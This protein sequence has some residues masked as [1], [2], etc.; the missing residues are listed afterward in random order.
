MAQM[1]SFT[2]GHSS[3]G[4]PL[5][6]WRQ[7]SLPMRRVLTI[8]TAIMLVVASLAVGT[9]TA[10]LPFWRRA[11]DL[12]LSRARTTCPRSRSARL[13]GGAVAAVDATANTRRSGGAV[14]CRRA[15]ARRGRRRLV[16]RAA[17]RA[18]VRRIFS[19]WQR[20]A[21]VAA[22]RFPGPAAGRARGGLAL[23]D[24]R[25]KSLD[26]RIA[27]YLPEWDDDPR[28]RI[29]LRQLLTETSGLAKG[30]DAAEV[31]GSHPF[32]DWSH[33][34]DFATS[35]GVRLLLGNDFESTAL[36]FELRSRAGRIL[37]RV[38]GERPARGGHRR[39]RLGYALRTIPRRSACLHLRT[40][41][42]CNCRWTARAACRRRIAAC[43]RWRATSAD[44]RIAA[45]RR[46]LRARRARVA[47]GLG[48]GDAQ[49]FAR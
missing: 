21:G 41:C 23:A 7:V 19:G 49:G 34:P 35:R 39:A 48:A 47:R 37:Q 32:E 26:D 44:R 22:G 12:P 24:G 11:F 45:Q 43:A 30:V 46:Q 25:I 6:A 31:L 13:P 17:R 29:T 9:L 8:L 38:A 2:G 4:R 15:R 28:G 36:G 18:A 3:H 16:S 5:V 1:E 40:C 42:T 20:L 33:L 27:K 10:D 14:S